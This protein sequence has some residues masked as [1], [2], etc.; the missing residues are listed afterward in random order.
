MCKIREFVYIRDSHQLICSNRRK[1]LVGYHL[2]LRPNLMA[3]NSNQSFTVSTTQTPTAIDNSADGG[4]PQLTPELE[5]V[6]NPQIFG[7]GLKCLAV[8]PENDLIAFRT[9][10]HLGGLCIVLV[11]P[12]RPWAYRVYNHL[13]GD[14][15]S[16]VQQMLITPFKQLITCTAIRG[17]SFKLQLVMV[18]G[19]DNRQICF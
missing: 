19:K 12:A 5:F 3:V 16:T 14:D 4:L 18:A 11:E 15:L 10:R 17:G 2:P 6:L 8:S 1:M 7:S 13:E 9:T